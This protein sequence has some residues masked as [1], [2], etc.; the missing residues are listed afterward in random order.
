MDEKRVSRVLTLYKKDLEGRLLNQSRGV[1][2]SSYGKLGKRNK[3]TKA[4]EEEV[5]EQAWDSTDEV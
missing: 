1:A 3:K 2:E 4:A 5:S